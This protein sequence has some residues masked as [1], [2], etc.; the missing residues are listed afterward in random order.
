[1]DLGYTFAHT[2]EAPLYAGVNKN[3]E[4]NE[5]HRLNYISQL[6]IASK[7][8]KSISLEILPTYVHRNFIAQRINTNNDAEDVNGFMSLGI[9]GRIKMT[10][11]VC[12][13]GD[14]FYNFSPFYQNND[15]ATMPLSFGVELET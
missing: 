1:G 8:S 4:T 9:G 15:K 11:R 3:F 10:K 13:I 6:I 7:V 12:L 2:N 14:Y 5:L